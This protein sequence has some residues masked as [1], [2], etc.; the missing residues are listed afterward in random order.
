MRDA[1]RDAF[2]P[3]QQYGHRFLGFF[4]YSPHGSMAARGAQNG[5]HIPLHGSRD[6]CGHH[7]QNALLQY[8]RAGYLMRSAVRRPSACQR[9]DL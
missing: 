7:A 6:V 2:F 4:A 5:Q 9:G 3:D 1:A 8:D